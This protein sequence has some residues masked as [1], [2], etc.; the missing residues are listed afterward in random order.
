MGAANQ[1]VVFS[2]LTIAVAVAMVFL[3]LSQGVPEADRQMNKIPCFRR[4]AIDEME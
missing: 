3:V 4:A 1:V 2:V